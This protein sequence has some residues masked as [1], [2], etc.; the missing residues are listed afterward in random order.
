MEITQY[1]D[2]TYLKT[3]QQAGLSDEETLKK[4]YELTDEALENNFFEVMIRPDFVKEIK[5]YLK[6]KNSHVKVGT[7]IGFHEGTA[8]TADKIAEAEK[9]ISDGV[10]ELDFVIN[11]E[12]F[13]AGNVDLVKNEFVSGTKLALEN[14]KVVKWIIEIAALTDAQIVDI[15]KNIRIWAEEHFAEDDLENI[16]V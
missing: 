14:N 5:A 7:V 6:S 11:Y 15:T 3:P 16:F 1:L 2:S 8:S 12:A 4:V 13:K 9:A 10:D